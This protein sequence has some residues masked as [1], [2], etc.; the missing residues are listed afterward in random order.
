MSTT[1]PPSAMQRNSFRVHY[2]WWIAFGLMAAFVFSTREMTLLDAKS[3]M[4]Q[5]YA[6]VP[7]LMLLH[8]IPGLIA[9]VI[10]P[11]QFS[12]WLRQRYRKLHRVAGRIY[13]GCVLI[14]APLAVIVAAVLP[15]PTLLEAS[16][17]QSMGWI[18]TTATAIYCILT[19]RTQQH[20]EWMMRSYPF[21]AVFVVVRAVVSI[22]AIDRMGT[23]GL[24]IAVWSCVALACMLPS[25]VIAWR[26][27]AVSKRAQK[28][29][30][31]LQGD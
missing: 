14:S 2:I 10:G 20:R 29:S 30:V 22:P 27:L 23:E 8:G 25:Y 16:A 15:V 5:R 3:F 21:A 11:F 12:T 18:V 13:A 7:L 19:G 17:I 26:G 28:P 6:P 1:A 4:R 24:E 9:L 31:T